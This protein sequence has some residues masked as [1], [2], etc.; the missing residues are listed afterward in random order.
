[1]QDQIKIIRNT[2]LLPG[3]HAKINKTDRGLYIII[4]RAQDLLIAR[5]LTPD[6]MPE[7]YVLFPGSHKAWPCAVYPLSSFELSDDY[8]VS[9]APCPQYEIQLFE[10][11]Q[12]VLL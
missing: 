8:L 6:S 10:R 7:K 2:M 12:V 11:L 5:Q 1:M 3:E 9:L 4:D